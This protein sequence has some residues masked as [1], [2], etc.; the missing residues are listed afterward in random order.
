MKCDRTPAARIIDLSQTGHPNSVKIEV[1]RYVCGVK[2]RPRTLPVTRRKIA[3]WFR[4]TPAAAIDAALK[5]LVDEQK[6][7]PSLTKTERYQAAKSSLPA[8]WR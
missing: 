3:Q 5:D 6:I 2:G 4:Q 1:L 7:V 8:V